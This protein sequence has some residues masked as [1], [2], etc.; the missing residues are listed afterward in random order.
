MQSIKGNA[1][2]LVKDFDVLCITTN[3]YIKNDGSCV[4]GRGI[5]LECSKIFPSIP[6]T[7]GSLIY[8]RG[9]HVYRLEKFKGCYLFS[10][11]VKHNWYEKADIELIKRSCSELL[12]FVDRFGYEKILLPR[13]GCGNGGLK[14]IE[15]EPILSEILDDRFYEL[16]FK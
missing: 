7:L 16:T 3:G 14:W 11:P 12:Y 2:K 9:N 5:A 6:I 13:P 4:M 15:V 1:W 8:E 10:F